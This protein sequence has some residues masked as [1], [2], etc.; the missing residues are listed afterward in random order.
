MKVNESDSTYYRPGAAFAQVIRAIGETT[1]ITTWIRLFR[2]WSLDC[3]S[4]ASKLQLVIRSR[5]TQ[6]GLFAGS[7]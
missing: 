1:A 6:N 4:R 3:E 7:G 2:Q 5:V